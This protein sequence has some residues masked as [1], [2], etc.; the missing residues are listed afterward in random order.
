VVMRQVMKIKKSKIFFHLK[1]K[2]LVEK[3]ELYWWEKTDWWVWN[4]WRQVNTQKRVNE[5]DQ[6]Y[7]K[8]RLTQLVELCKHW[9]VEEDEQQ[10]NTKLWLPRPVV[11]SVSLV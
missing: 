6:E 9:K 2:G 7:A 3:F 1:K 8:N 5:E 4:I 11:G 10:E